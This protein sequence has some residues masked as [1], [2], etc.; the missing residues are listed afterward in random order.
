MR[1]IVLRR[2]RSWTSK[3][4]ERSHKSCWFHM[5]SLQEMSPIPACQ[6][7]VSSATSFCYFAYSERFPRFLS[8]SQTMYCWNQTNRRVA[9]LQSFQITGFPPSQLQA[10]WSKLSP[11]QSSLQLQHAVVLIFLFVGDLHH[12]DIHNIRSSAVLFDTLIAPRRVHLR[13][14]IHF[15]KRSRSEQNLHVFITCSCPLQFECWSLLDSIMF[16]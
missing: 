12:S 14:S 13:Y 3:N 15:E 5:A 9:F 4:R 10:I 1:L 6:G 8:S 2:R 16:L 11:F 7:F